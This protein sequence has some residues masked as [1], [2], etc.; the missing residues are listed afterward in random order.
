MTPASNLRPRS[1]KDRSIE[2][3]IATLP[4]D[5]LQT[6]LSATGYAVTP[7][8]LTSAECV[9]LRSLYH[10]EELFRSKVI[11][12]RLRFGRGDYQ[13][14]A[15]PLPPLVQELRT[16]AYPPL[17]AVA[18]AWA[19]ALGQKDRFPHAHNDFLELCHR[20]GQKRP[21]PLLLH[22]EQDGYNCLHQ[23]IYGAVAFPLQMVVL[24]GQ[25]GR[26][27]QGGEFVLVEQRPR[28]QSS[29]EVMS[30]D[31]GCAVIFT[32]RYRPVQG[33]KGYYRVNM[34]HGVAR[35]RSGR[36][37]TLGVIFHDAE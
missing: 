32:T 21:T 13:Y 5:D 18:N 30:P 29:A 8:L 34:K 10:R 26:D 23:D 35:V 19:E 17:A 4:W 3:R 20:A 36:R 25:Q 14:F 31:E 27:W 2:D 11:M 37:Y 22:Y 28:A 33:S 6:A 1:G 9:E 12:E 15:N 7:P 24:L 16:H